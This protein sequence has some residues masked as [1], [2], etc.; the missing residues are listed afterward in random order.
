M[1]QQNKF[2]FLR[3]YLSRPENAAVK[4]QVEEYQKAQNNDGINKIIAE[5][6]VKEKE[7]LAKIMKPMFSEE[8]KNAYSTL[9]GSPHLDGGYTVFGEVIEGLEV[10]D[11]IA[12]SETDKNNRPT[13][14][15]A[16][17]V[18]IID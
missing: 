7:A 5:I 10:I 6:E 16:M 13:K 8:Q 3:E 4:K 14:D 2:T 1:N 17:K 12:A 15:V 18:T 11:K 9:G